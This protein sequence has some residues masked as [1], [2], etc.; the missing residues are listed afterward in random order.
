MSDIEEVFDH[1]R[2][3]MN[4]ST[5][6]VLDEARKNKISARIKS[7]GIGTCKRAIDGNASSEWHQGANNR[8][9]KYNDINLI[10]RN[11]DKTEMFSAM[12]DDRDSYER[13]KREWLE[14]GQ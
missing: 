6:T 12:A 1:W 3:R 14:E 2:D 7:H 8:R 9:K 5:R 11:A 4:K 10:L 13:D